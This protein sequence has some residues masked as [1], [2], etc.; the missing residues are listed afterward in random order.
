MCPKF[1]YYAVKTLN[2]EQKR[3]ARQMRLGLLLEMSTNGIPGQLSGFVV[4]NFD[5]ATMNLNLPAGSIEI[6][7]LD[8]K[9]FLCEYFDKFQFHC[10]F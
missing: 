7:E 1:L 8:Y 2:K 4:E 6:R 10:E 9:K 3:A 5:P